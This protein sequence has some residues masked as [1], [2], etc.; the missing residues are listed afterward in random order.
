MH[1][2]GEKVSEIFTNYI[3]KYIWENGYMS[4]SKYM[5]IYRIDIFLVSVILVI[6]TDFEGGPLKVCYHILFQFNNIQV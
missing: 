5:I 4:A 6:Y 3:I 2:I 1:F